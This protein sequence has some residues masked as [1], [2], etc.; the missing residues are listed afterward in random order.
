LVTEWREF[1]DD[2]PGERFEHH[3]QRMRQ[4]GSRAGAI[5]RIVVG[6]LL[7]VAGIVM[8]VIPGP[9]L[10]AMLFGF[11]LIGGSSKTIARAL[12]RIE[13]GMR[14]QGRRAVRAF[15]HSSPIVKGLIVVVA[16]AAC[17]G[18]AWLMWHYVIH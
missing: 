8:L 3:Y 10:V 6:V 18:A 17:A 2:S 14:R 16:A 4:H 12:D 5:A 15:R 11:G 7:V 1:R 9:G 13:P